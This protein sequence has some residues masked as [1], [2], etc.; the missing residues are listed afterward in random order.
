MIPSCATKACQ[1]TCSK[2]YQKVCQ[3]TVAA[4]MKENPQLSTNYKIP[5]AVNCCKPVKR[6]EASDV[7]KKNDEPKFVWLKFHKSKIQEP[8]IVLRI[9]RLDT[10]DNQRKLV[11]AKESPVPMVKHKWQRGRAACFA[12]EPKCSWVHDLC[13]DPRVGWMKL[14][15]GHQECQCMHTVFLACSIMNSRPNRHWW[16]SFHVN[17][18]N[19]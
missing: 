10:A 8:R 19:P 18:G 4:R 15:K 5:V 7:G 16:Y 13:H 2:L 3:E 12:L 1:E 14:G 17:H 11:T 6:M 9:R